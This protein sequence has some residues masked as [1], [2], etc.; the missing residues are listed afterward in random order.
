MNENEA[1]I[2]AFYTCFQRLDWRGMA[3][4]YHPEAFFYDPVFE[5]LQGARIAG[6][7]E[8]L[9]GGAKD[10]RLECSGV[11][12]DAEY[13]HCRWTAYYTFSRTGRPVIN[14]VH[15]HFR[16]SGGKIAEHH[17]DF[18][19]WRWNR[20]AFGLSGLLFG[21]TPVMQKKV[22]KMAKKGL[23]KFMA[24]RRIEP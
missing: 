7:W 9:L 18:D 16:F 1:L 13:G 21:W 24:G 14:K 15:A 22:R 20:Q 5:D 17:D 3:A 19:L 10:L 2:T 23:D 6:M 4:C 11:S 12:A 8:M